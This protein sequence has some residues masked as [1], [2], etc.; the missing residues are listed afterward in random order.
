VEG[1]FEWV[2]AGTYTYHVIFDGSPGVVTTILGLRIRPVML[3]TEEIMR[4][5]RRML[6]DPRPDD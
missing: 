3:T 6:D 1:V 5:L 2:P 4:E